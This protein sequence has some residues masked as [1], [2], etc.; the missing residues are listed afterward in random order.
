MNQDKNNRTHQASDVVL[1]QPQLLLG[2][3]SGAALLRLLRG[4]EVVRLTEHGLGPGYDDK[5]SDVGLVKKNRFENSMY[6]A[7]PRNETHQSQG[8]RTTM[9]HS[10]SS[11]AFI[12]PNSLM[13]NGSCRNM[14]L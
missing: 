6:D 3:S 1:I 2:I 9:I 4:A 7:P 8:E 11:L 12:S 10:M 13:S 5:K 14:C